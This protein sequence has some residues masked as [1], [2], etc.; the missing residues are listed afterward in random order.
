MYVSSVKLAAWWPSHRC[1]CTALRPSAKRLDNQLHDPGREGARALIVLFYPGTVGQN[2]LSA[3][4]LPNQPLTPSR[5][6]A[7]RERLHRGPDRCVGQ[8]AALPG[9][10]PRQPSDE[11]GDHPRRQLGELEPRGEVAQREALE[12]RPVLVSGLI[13]EAP[14]AGAL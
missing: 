2:R 7:C 9:R 8:R 5:R 6:H 1:T 11:V 12:L 10:L 3:R 4:V 13:A 14:P